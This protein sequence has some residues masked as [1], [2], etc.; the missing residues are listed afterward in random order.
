MEDQRL[1][2]EA[3][4]H[5]VH[6]GSDRAQRIGFTGPP[7]AGKSTLAE[8][9][10]LRCRDRDL[11]VGILAVDPSSPFTGGA[12]LGDRIRMQEL[13]LDEGVFI[14][15]MASRGRLGGLAT[16]SLEAADLMEAF[17]FDVVV[18][19]TVGVGQTELDI[20]SAADTTVVVLVPESGDSI[21]AM[22]AGLMEIADVLVVNKSDR[23][24]ADRMV[25]DLRTTLGLRSERDDAWAPPIVKTVAVSGE[26]VEDVEK[27]IAAHREHGTQT[28]ALET[29]RRR[30]IAERV[31]EL[32]TRRF[33][34]AVW[35]DR[36]GEALLRDAT[37]RILSG[38]A[39]PYSIAGEII[40]AAG[41]ELEGARS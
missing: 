30:R 24:G 37:D 25:R 32:V 6:Q 28:G 29:K 16:T 1:N 26:G 38:E 3:L 20:V 34:R 40:S 10:A 17:G 13:T 35:L 2:F 33:E 36:G 11:T 14:R 4:L 5:S 22:K 8:K 39:T 23:P 41:F 27:A 15:S 31:R 19:E 9:F 7:G 12:L 21:Q 18:H